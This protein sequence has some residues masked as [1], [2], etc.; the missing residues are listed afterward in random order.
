MTL[1]T[2]DT[3]P[4]TSAEAIR[5]FDERYLAAQGVVQPDGWAETFGDFSPVSSP[6]VTFPVSQVSGKYQATSG[7]SQFKTLQETSFDIKVSE[8]D[9]GYEAKLMDLYTEI[10]AYRKWK[11]VPNLFM[12]GEANHRADNIA[13]LLEANPTLWDGKAL[14]ATDHPANFFEPAKGTFG[15]LNAAALDVE[16]IVNIAAQITIM[17]GVLDENGKKMGVNPDT[18]FLPTAKF[19]SVKNLLSQAM[20][21]NAAGTAS[22]N[23]P[24][25]NSIQCVHVPQLTDANDWYLVDSKL[26]KTLPAWAMLKYAPPASLGLRTFD[27]SSDF[28][29]ATG[30][31]K[32]SS[33]IWYGFGAVFPHAIRRVTGA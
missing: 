18:L 20:I 24:Y 1:Y 10:Y 22:V 19:E 33:H 30:K 25:L 28:F 4:T 23:N 7:D 9:L 32:V 26:I 11:N 21:G 14:F 3:L 8:F 13:A 12:T 6:R 31:I 15:N 16:S 27:E 17:R 5:V 29:K 2:I